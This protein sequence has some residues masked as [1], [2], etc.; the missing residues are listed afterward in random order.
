MQGILTVIAERQ[1]ARRGR[2]GRLGVEIPLGAG[3]NGKRAAGIERCNGWFEWMKALKTV[4]LG[5]DV[6]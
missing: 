6:A 4:I 3:T 2:Q 1:G 5:V